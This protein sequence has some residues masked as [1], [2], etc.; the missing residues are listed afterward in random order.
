V[1]LANF[2]KEAAP[3]GAPPPRETLL[4]CTVAEVM[5][6]EI[7]PECAAFYLIPAGSGPR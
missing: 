2:T 7:P 3:L 6:S 4:Y 5:D 1:L